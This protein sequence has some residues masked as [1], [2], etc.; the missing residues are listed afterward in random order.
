MTPGGPEE[1]E[2]IL[3]A[4]CPQG[5]GGYIDIYIYIYIRIYYN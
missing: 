3:A 5:A 1:E 2:V 4:V